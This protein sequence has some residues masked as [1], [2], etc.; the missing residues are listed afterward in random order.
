MPYQDDLGQVTGAFNSLMSG[1][2]QIVCHV[3][4]S[5]VRLRIAATDMVSVADR[6]REGSAR[7]QTSSHEAAAIVETLHGTIADLNR[8]AEE[9]GR[10]TET[11]TTAAAECSVVVS[12]AGQAIQETSH[13]VGS[14]AVQLED[15]GRHSGEVDAI[16]QIIREIANQT[17][18]LARNAAI[19]AA[20]AGELGR[21][22]AVVADEVRKLA[23]K[24]DVATTKI[25]EILSTIRCEIEQSIK[26][27]N[28]CQ[29]RTGE[30]AGL[31]SEAGK[32][33]RQVQVTGEQVSQVV[34]GIV[35]AANSQQQAAAA[36][37]C[38]V[39]AIAHLAQS[40]QEQVRA[41]SDAAEDLQRMATDLKQTVA[42][43]KT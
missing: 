4:E 34:A 11:S 23:D 8:Q 39:E 6:V 3:L 38:H 37:V 28:D 10:L 29:Q 18:L 15:L 16:V 33:M 41:T 30:I 2:Q 24:T 26:G 42:D 13:S 32:A 35:R 7:Q 14:L 36:I 9:A 12:Q 21:G 27:I 25:T 22:F 40:N 17:N 19:E 5:M 1:L 43:F 31:S 20:R